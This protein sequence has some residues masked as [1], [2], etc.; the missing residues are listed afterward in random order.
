MLVWVNGVRVLL[1]TNSA[2][3]SSS[4]KYIGGSYNGNYWGGYITQPAFWSKELSEEE[5]LY[6][7]G[8]GN[9]VKYINW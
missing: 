8:D 1:T 9:G 4:T 2:T 5:I 7:Y 6:L 3:L